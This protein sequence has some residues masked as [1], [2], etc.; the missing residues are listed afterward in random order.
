MES[1]TVILV[2][3]DD[4]ILKKLLSRAFAD[5]YNM[6]YANNGAE[7]LALLDTQTPTLILL[8]LLMP[9]MDGFTFLEKVRAR[10]DAVKSTPIIVVS[11]LGQ[12]KDIDRVKA[13]GV[14]AYLVKAEV[15]IDEITAKINEVLS[16]LPAK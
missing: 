10:N 7:A 15:S 8:D 5:Q 6:L 2:V 16:T 14:S 9:D 12:Q 11:N 4:I 3:E 1:D 13:L